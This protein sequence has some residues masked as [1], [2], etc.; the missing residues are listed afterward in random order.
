MKRMSCLK[1]Q[2]KLID[3]QQ[4]I[5]ED[6]IKDKK[7]SE[8]NYSKWAGELKDNNTRRDESLERLI[9]KIGRL[10]D[11]S[12]SKELSRI[13]NVENL[14]ANKGLFSKASIEYDD[15]YDDLVEELKEC[16]NNSLR[17]QISN[18]NR[19]VAQDNT[20]L[21]NEIRKLG[22]NS[23]SDNSFR[24]EIIDEIRKLK[25]TQVQ[26]IAQPNNN[27]ELISEIRRL[28]DKINSSD[29]TSAKGNK[30]IEK[31]NRN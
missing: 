23:N 11:L 22:K 25:N 18:N 15:D 5:I 21:I 19:V 8:Q 4:S 9:P 29:T 13:H 14:L 6:L 2:Q 1:P 7:N 30:G 12:E 26:P 20:E 28:G 31:H 24:N 27:I 17:N 3:N 10:Q 16:E